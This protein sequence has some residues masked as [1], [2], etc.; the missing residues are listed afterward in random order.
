M[1]GYPGLTRKQRLVLIFLALSTL[2][3]IS[4]LIW[5]VWSTLQ[6]GPPAAPTS[7]PLKLSLPTPTLTPQP[8]VI[9]SPTPTP[10]FDVAEAGQIAA[11]VAEVRGFQGFWGTPL[12]LVDEHNL[13]VALFRYYGAYPPFVL[14]SE[15]I[16]DVLNLRPIDQALSDKTVTS[17]LD[18]VAHAKSAAAIYFPKT[19][20]F[21]FRRDWTGTLD[22]LEM[23]LAYRL[24]SC[25]PRSVWRLDQIDC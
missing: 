10:T 19:E 3:I 1:R 21:Y 13:S 14:T 9:T 5:N 6:A 22:V 8:T 11:R 20:E 16:W 24:C 2:T 18:V 23:Q 4:L 12:T 17:A 15:I 7:T 25:P